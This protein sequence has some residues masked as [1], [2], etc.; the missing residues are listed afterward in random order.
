[1]LDTD[2]E[3]LIRTNSE[4]KRLY[5]EHISLEQDLEALYSLKYFP[6]EVETRIKELKVIKLRGKDRMQQIITENKLSE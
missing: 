5:D 4:F 2:V 6:P 1:M 3:E